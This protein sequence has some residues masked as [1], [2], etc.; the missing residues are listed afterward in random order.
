MKVSKKYNL[1][2]RTTIKDLY[3][4]VEVFF[5][6]FKKKSHQP[7]VY[8][9]EVTK[10]TEEEIQIEQRLNALI[11]LKALLIAVGE[12]DEITQREY[13]QQLDLTFELLKW[14]K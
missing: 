2:L 3:L 9:Y 12:F 14:K 11:L 1:L 13:D 6:F 5:Y 8:H 4:K 10:M 7:S